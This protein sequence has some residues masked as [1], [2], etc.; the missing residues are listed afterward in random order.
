MDYR[1]HFSINF[2]KSQLDYLRGVAS[3]HSINVSKLIEFMV[4]LCSNNHDVFVEFV[5]KEIDREKSK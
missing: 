2:Y 5:K 4:R 1:Q 3:I